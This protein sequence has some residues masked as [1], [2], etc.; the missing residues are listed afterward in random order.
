MN[1]ILLFFRGEFRADKNV[2]YGVRADGS[3]G[4][5]SGSISVRPPYSVT[6]TSVHGFHRLY[7][8][9]NRQTLSIHKTEKSIADQRNN[10]TRFMIHGKLTASGASLLIGPVLF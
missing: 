9:S 5:G 8:P 3:A 2:G 4:G 10:L 7:Q 6:V 1:C